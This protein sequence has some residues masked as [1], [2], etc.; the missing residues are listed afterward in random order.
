[1]EF[2]VGNRSF[3]FVPDALVIAGYTGRD[4]NTVDAHIAELAEE[5]IAPPSSVPAFFSASPDALLV[6]D[7]IEVLHSET[8]GEV[9]VVLVVDG[10]D[11]YVGVGS[12]HTDRRAER[13]DIG[14][15][16]QLCKKPLGRELWPLSTV[17]GRWE[18]LSLVSDITVGGSK[19]RY[20]QGSASANLSP[21]ALL[22]MIPFRIRPARFVLFTGTI[23][24]VG[25]I[26]HADCFEA[27]IKDAGLGKS[28]DLSYAIRVQ[29]ALTNG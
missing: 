21:E 13:L 23:P 2:L 27:S 5:G 8:S 1:M 15:S 11:A 7:Q 20:Q 17:E 12:D 25:G 28:L 19:D 26:R 6:G 4:R 9:E 18:D 14:V 22:E 24:V 29:N 16:K 10:G 3:E